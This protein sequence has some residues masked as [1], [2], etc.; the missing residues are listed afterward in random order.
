MTSIREYISD[1]A[2]QSDSE[3]IL[4]SENFDKAIIGVQHKDGLV[5]AVY[6]ETKILSELQDSMDCD[7]DEA[8]EFFDFNIESAYIGRQTPLYID[9]SFIEVE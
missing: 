4:L 7:L 5:I 8:K 9:D 2:E 3:T 1:I 6:S